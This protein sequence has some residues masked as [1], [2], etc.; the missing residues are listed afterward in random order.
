MIIHLLNM[1]LASWFTFNK[2]KNISAKVLQIYRNGNKSGYIPDRKWH[3][4]KYMLTP[5][6]LSILDWNIG[7]ELSLHAV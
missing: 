3:Q 5:V 7:K 4:P 2:K 6:K 1:S